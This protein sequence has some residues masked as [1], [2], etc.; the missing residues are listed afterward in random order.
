MFSNK[1]LFALPIVLGSLLGADAAFSATTVS[2][3]SGCVMKAGG[4]AGSGGAPQTVW[5][6]VREPSWGE[7]A[8]WQESYTFGKKNVLAYRLL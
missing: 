5:A 3:I 6:E 1:I 4:A 2:G 8:E 7:Y